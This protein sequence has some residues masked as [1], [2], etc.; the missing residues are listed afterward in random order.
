[1]SNTCR[2]NSKGKVEICVV[3]C[4]L[5]VS[6]ASDSRYTRRRQI[7][8]VLRIMSVA[9]VK[10]FSVLPMRGSIRMDRK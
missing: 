7:D 9:F 2:N 8:T 4:R 3:V 10:K 1:M 6:A 5:I